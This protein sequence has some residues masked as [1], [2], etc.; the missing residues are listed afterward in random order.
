MKFR[1]RLGKY[2]PHI[3]FVL[4]FWLCKFL[5]FKSFHQKRSSAFH[6]KW[7]FE[8]VMKSG[9]ERDYSP[10]LHNRIF[11]KTGKNNKNGIFSNFFRWESVSLRLWRE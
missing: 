6:D 3:F 1:K 7:F 5:T 2:Y 9:Q 8:S 4:L 10:A 11:Q